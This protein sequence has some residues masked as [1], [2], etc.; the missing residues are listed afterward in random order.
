MLQEEQPSKRRKKSDTEEHGL[1]DSIY[2]K[3]LGKANIER[4]KAGYW[5][6]GIRPGYGDELHMD[7]EIFLR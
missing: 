3:C 6:I 5:K 7:T 4:Q 2:M 1:C